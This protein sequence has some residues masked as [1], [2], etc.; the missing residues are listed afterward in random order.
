MRA[1][2]FLLL[3]CFAFKSHA[4]DNEAELDDS[5]TIQVLNTKTFL[6]DTAIFKKGI[7][8]RIS[9]T[10]H[11]SAPAPSHSH[12]ELNLSYQSDDVYNGRKNSTVIPLITP[13][14]SYIFKN[15]LQFDA[16]VGYDLHDPSPQTNQ[17]IF[18]G[19]YNY[20]P[21]NGN[22]SASVTASA[23][24]YNKQSGNTTAEQR[25]SIEIDNSY[26]FNFIQPSLYLTWCF[27]G[28]K[29][30]ATTFS[31]QH[32]FDLL[33]NKLNITPT[34]NVNAGTQ[35][36]LDSYYKNRKYKVHQKK[37]PPVCE[38]VTVYGDVLNAG[39]F[40]VLDYEIAVP[41][42]YSYKRFT[43][44]IT[45]NYSIPVHA[46][47]TVITTSYQGQ[48]LKTSYK[49]ENISNTFYYQAGV[50]YDF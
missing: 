41:V 21:G 43:F 39:K 49:K 2:I 10:V 45:P 7:M 5:L 35:N 28:G 40:I 11:T 18:D 22:Y 33:K 16:S 13:R 14:V 44:N 9:R 34:F 19:V 12:L 26:D 27:G 47:E 46:A 50:T 6:D 24:I 17:Y 38:E 32:E 4:Q 37:E 31:L 20:S 30:Y 1:A 42:S 23:F 15:G 48:I 3:I 8:Q 25:G 29:D 36:F